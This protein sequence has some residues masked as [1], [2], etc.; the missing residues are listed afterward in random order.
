[1]FVYTIALYIIVFIKFALNVLKTGSKRLKT[2]QND[3]L[4]YFTTIHRDLARHYTTYMCA[5]KQDKNNIIN[6]EPLY[7]NIQQ[8]TSKQTKQLYNSNIDHYTN[9]I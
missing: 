6:Y 1:M 2:A 7:N 9:T 3:P 5:K 4:L 8:Y